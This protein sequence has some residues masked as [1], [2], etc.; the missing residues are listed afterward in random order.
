MPEN[1]R[2]E[3][4]LRAGAPVAVGPVTLVPIERVVLNA[5]RG[6]GMAWFAALKEPYALIVRDARG[7]RAVDARAAPL[8][9]DA[10]R[11]TVAGLDAVLAA[12]SET[13]ARP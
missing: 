2:R 7:L 1:G 13:I 11:E 5:E 4:A 10:L 3:E 6:A 9:L 12:L 8:S